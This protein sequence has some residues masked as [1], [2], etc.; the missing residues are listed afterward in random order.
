ML[1]LLG[2]F[3]VLPEGKDD[4]NHAQQKVLFTPRKILRTKEY[5]LIVLGLLF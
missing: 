3:I 4:I 5:Y 1:S 2:M